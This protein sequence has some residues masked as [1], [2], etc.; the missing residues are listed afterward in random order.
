[1]NFI[2]TF[3]CQ[4]NKQNQHTYK[5]KKLWKISFPKDKLAQ[6]EIVKK[7]EAERKVRE[8]NKKLIE[9]YTQKIQDRMNKVW[10]ED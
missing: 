1:M 9:T 6:K 4:N 10:G 8:G 5:W 3:L 7:I 2:K